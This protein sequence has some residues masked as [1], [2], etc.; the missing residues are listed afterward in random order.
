MSNASLLRDPSD[1]DQQATSLLR[2]AVPTR[3]HAAPALEQLQDQAAGTARVFVPLGP[4]LPF[5]PG[6]FEMNHNRVVDERFRYDGIHGFLHRMYRRFGHDTYQRVAY[7]REEIKKGRVPYSVPDIADMGECEVHNR[8]M[9]FYL[10]P[11]S[12]FF[13]HTVSTSFLFFA[14]FLLDPFQH[15]NN[16]KNKNPQWRGLARTCILFYFPI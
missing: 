5:P 13:F 16:N 9:A 7:W 8:P 11:L 15:H 14:S 12:F 6:R 2:S 10:P 1:L 4:P 3:W